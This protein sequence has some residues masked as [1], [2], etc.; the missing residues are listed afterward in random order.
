MHDNLGSYKCFKCPVCKSDII[1]SYSILLKLK[2]SLDQYLAMV[3]YKRKRVIHEKKDFFIK[4]EKVNFTKSHKEYISKFIH[5]NIDC[6]KCYHKRRLSVLN[7]E[8]NGELEEDFCIFWSITFPLNKGKY[9][10]IDLNNECLGYYQNGDKKSRIDV[11]LLLETPESENTLVN[12]G[13]YEVA[14]ISETPTIQIA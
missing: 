7:P 3:C 14:E 10:Q 12:E 6:N 13:S 4:G 8:F 5:K 1:V 9:Y 2:I 11:L